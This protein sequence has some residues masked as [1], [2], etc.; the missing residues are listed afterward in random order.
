MFP[1]LSVLVSFRDIGSHNGD[2]IGKNNPCRSFRQWHRFRTNVGLMRKPDVIL[3]SFDQIPVW[4][5]RIVNGNSFPV[6]KFSF[7]ADRPHY[8]TTGTYRN[9]SLWIVYMLPMCTLKK[10]PVRYNIL[11]KSMVL[12]KD[13]YKL[14][15]T[16]IIR[17][18]GVCVLN[19]ARG[20]SAN[21]GWLGPKLS[22]FLYCARQFAQLCHRSHYRSTVPPLTIMA[23]PS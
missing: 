16:K 13:K 20:S 3:W 19:K 21:G 14:R 1:L 2:S 7:A 9:Q 12:G 5:W 17:Q 15:R 11:S 22:L 8:T 18:A 23:K 6:I 10:A 4:S